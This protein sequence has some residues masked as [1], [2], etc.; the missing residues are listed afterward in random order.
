MARRFPDNHSYPWMRKQRRSA[1]GLLFGL[2]GQQ[3]S[4]I[5]A[6]LLSE[7]P[8][9]PSTCSAVCR[10]AR[11]FYQTTG[12]KQA[13]RSICLCRYST[14][15]GMA[16]LQSGLKDSPL[17]AW[18]LPRTP[19][20][21]AKESDLSQLQGC[22]IVRHKTPI[23]VRARS[24]RTPFR[25]HVCYGR[26]HGSPDLQICKQVGTRESSKGDSLFVIPL[27]P[28]R[29]NIPFSSLMFWDNISEISMMSAQVAHS[30]RTASSGGMAH[31]ILDGM[32]EVLQ[33]A[34]Q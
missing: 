23:E 20:M 4:C 29:V 33:I 30:C 7:E 32:T 25:Q 27:R 14:H 12:D 28:A 22:Y 21:N 16:A 13:V 10:N 31:F 2:V 9:H 26:L 3:Q 24:S 34:H 18:L 1:V 17:P 6:L 8:F 5:G 15:L 19:T 11:I